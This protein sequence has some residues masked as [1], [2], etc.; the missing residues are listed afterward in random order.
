MPSP[1]CKFCTS[2]SLRVSKFRMGDMSHLLLFQFP[3]RCRSC[4]QRTYLSFHV[5]LRLPHR[6]K[7]ST[8]VKSVS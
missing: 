5:A 2:K 4:R 1:I 3:V 6:S 7:H 8:P